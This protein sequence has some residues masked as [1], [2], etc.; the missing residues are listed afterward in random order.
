MTLN[1]AA[2]RLELAR[3][4][5]L[6]AYRGLV[7]DILGHISLR[8]DEERMLLRCRGDEEI[9]LRFTRPNDI[10]LVDIRSGQI[11]EPEGGFKPPSETP[12]H[13]QVL[14]ARA[15][16]DS[17]VHV[18]PPEV[19]VA[20]LGDLPLQPFIGAFNMPAMRIADA[21]IPTYPRSV[22]IR[23]A[24][25]GQDMTKSL[26]A[27]QVLLLK[28]HGLVTTG[29]SPAEAML[30]ALHVDTLARLFLRA[31]NAGITPEPISEADKADLPDLGAGFNEQT[32]WRYHLA[33]L[34]ADGWDI[35]K[36]MQ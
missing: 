29:R 9:G 33:S 22:L 30:N 15:D 23:S 31:R 25:L 20:A 4:C 17:V 35:E 34:A 11:L 8:V 1:F 28:G 6:M 19:V 13:S 3:C 10:R 7:D 16:V 5:R 32:L 14:M 21:G 2:E 12:I 36:E 18:H 26:G 24:Q 27:A